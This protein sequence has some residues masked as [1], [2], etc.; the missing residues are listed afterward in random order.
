M[1]IIIPRALVATTPATFLNDIISLEEVY[2]K[3]EIVNVLKSTRE[4][5]SNKVCI[6]VAERYQIPAF[7]R[8]AI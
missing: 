6:L 7:A 5:I 3:D 1:D 4:R 2:T 8:F